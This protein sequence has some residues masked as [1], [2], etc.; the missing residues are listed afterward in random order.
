MF[1]SFE[2]NYDLV[3]LLDLCILEFESQNFSKNLKCR[4]FKRKKE[5]FLHSIDTSQKMGKSFQ[6]YVFP[7]EGMKK[8]EEKRVIL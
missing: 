6:R 4:C 5:F 3:Q 8:K 2:K 1:V 7:A